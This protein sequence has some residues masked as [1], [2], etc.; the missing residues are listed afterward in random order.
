MIYLLGF[1]VLILVIVLFLTSK[2][3]YEN[4]VNN[5]GHDDVKKAYAECCKC[6]NSKC[7]NKPEFLNDPN[8]EEK[9]KQTAEQ[10]QKQY[11]QQFTKEEYMKLLEQVKVDK[12]S[13]ED[14]L[15]LRELRGEA[16][17]EQPNVEQP[18]VEQPT[19]ENFET[20]L[21]NF[22][23]DPDGTKQKLSECCDKEKCLDKPLMFADKDCKEKTLE[24]N[25]QLFAQYKPEYTDEEYKI[26]VD[27][28]KN[29][30]HQ[31]LNNLTADPNNPIIYHPKEEIDSGLPELINL[32]I[33]KDTSLQ[34]PGF[35][36]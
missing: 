31:S 27:N 33:D 14:L 15:A 17:I 32:T 5:V 3:I 28:I 22:S 20:K 24:L 1:I 6:K 26:L 29:R 21:I 7:H 4:L 25:K 16:N 12:V 19:E 34:L 9:S 23:S 8:C 35:N 11:E 30:P 18:T 10:L 2:S 36:L 13:R